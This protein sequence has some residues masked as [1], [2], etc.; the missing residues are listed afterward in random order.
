MICG[1]CQLSELYTDTCHNTVILTKSLGLREKLSA[2][3]AVFL[4]F[5]AQ[6]ESREMNAVNQG[7]H[8]NQ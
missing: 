2:L 6:S 1:N 8:R 4:P 7:G 5:P 3:W